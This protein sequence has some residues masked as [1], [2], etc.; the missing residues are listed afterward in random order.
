[1]NEAYERCQSNTEDEKYQVYPA[2]DENG[3][4]VVRHMSAGIQGKIFV[5]GDS[6]YEFFIMSVSVSETRARFNSLA[7]SERAEDGR[8]TQG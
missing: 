6:S 3:Q 7:A 5:M 4:Q 2:T 8:P 1:L